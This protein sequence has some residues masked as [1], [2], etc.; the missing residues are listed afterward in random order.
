MT[1]SI[2][3]PKPVSRRTLAKGAAWSAPAIALAVAAPAHAASGQPEPCQVDPGITLAPNSSRNFRAI[4]TTQSQNLNPTTIFQNYGTG[5]L[6][7]SL[8]ICNCVDTQ[9]WYRWRET[10][11][12]SNFQIEV[13]G[14]HVDQNSA[15]A[16]YRAAFQLPAFGSVGGCRE[17]RLSYRTSLSRPLTDTSF[18]ITLVLQRGPSQ[19]GPW[20]QIQSFTRTVTVKRNAGPGPQNVNFNSC[21]V[22]GRAAQGASEPEKSQ[23]TDPA[24]VEDTNA[25]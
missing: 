21:A 2:E 5:M 16:G 14:A 23:A 20:T 13:D 6:P 17:F 22:Q 1:V 24:A 25:D 4:C 18:T 7:A 10:D 19:T 12:L 9:Q 11:T 15:A 8:R 3:N